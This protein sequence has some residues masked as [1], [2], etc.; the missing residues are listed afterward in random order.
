MLII[1][2][3]VV[4]LHS[5]LKR[6]IFME[7][8]ASNRI[9]FITYYCQKI[10]NKI[11]TQNIAKIKAVCEKQKIKSLFSFGSVCTDKFNEQSDVDLLVTFKQMDFGDYADNYFQTAD[12]FE[13]IFNRKV[14]LITEKSLKNPYFIQSVNQTK[15]L[16]Y[17][18]Q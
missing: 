8:K 16:L 12:L 18:G 4:P 13:K 3:K 2:K 6:N 5:F 9:S 1:Q 7:R 14:D 17:D 10:M 15:T 11:I